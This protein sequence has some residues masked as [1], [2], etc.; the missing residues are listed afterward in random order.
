MPTI[1]ANSAMVP[2]AVIL[3]C[4]TGRQLRNPDA[5]SVSDSVMPKLTRR[6]RRR[7][8]ARESTW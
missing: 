7:R 2:P 6:H 4:A 3:V 8:T 5:L 1:D